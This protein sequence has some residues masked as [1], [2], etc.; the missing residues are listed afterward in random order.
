MRI[1][2]YGLQ[3]SGASL[4]T[5]WLSQLEGYCGVID[6]FVREPTPRAPR[7]G[8][9]N[10]VLKAVVSNRNV[11]KQITRF[12]P[13]ISIL[14]IRDPYHNYASLST[15]PFRDRGG[16]I[17]EKFAALDILVGKTRSANSQFDTIIRYEDFIQY[18]E[19]IIRKLN[20]VGVPVDS[21]NYVFRRSV[22]DVVAFTAAHSK[23]LARAYTKTW[24]TGNIHQIDVDSALELK[25]PDVSHD[26]EKAM[27]KWCPNLLS[28]YGYR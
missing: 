26:I 21:S 19:D 7:I 9:E 4:F 28:Y 16:S 12:Q 27:E 24:G 2:V 20:A 14:Y 5:Y 22:D 10:V 6:L 11:A 3:S 23:L 17:D 13:D 1:F 15:K 18:P 8:C 25:Q